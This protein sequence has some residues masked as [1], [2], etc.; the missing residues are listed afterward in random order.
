MV[1]G[2]RAQ[3]ADVHDQRTVERYSCMS[4]SVTDRGASVRP[5]PIASRS[6]IV[7]AMAMHVPHHR[8]TAPGEK[9][10]DAQERI[11]HQ[12]AHEYDA[13]KDDSVPHLTSPHLT[14]PHLTGGRAARYPQVHTLSNQMSVVNSL[15][16]MKR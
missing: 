2:E 6:R 5:G 3:R 4:P 1:G 7:H 11:A 15:T 16:G 9:G 10:A 12:Y 13:P 14:S 8:R